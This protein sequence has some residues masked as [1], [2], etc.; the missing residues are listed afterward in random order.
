M[1]REIFTIANLLSLSR[2]ILI[3]P[4]VLVMLVPGAPARW[5]GVGILL[6]ATLTDKLDG[7]AARA[8]HQE[9]ELGR[10]LDPLADKLGVAA[11]AIVFLYLQWLPL[12]FVALLL[13]RDVLILTGGLIVRRK[14]G[15]VLPSNVAGKWSIGVFAA[16]L[17]FVLVDAPPWLLSIGIWTSVT[18]VLVS[19]IGYVRRFAEVMRGHTV[20]S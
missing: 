15:E 1:K 16:T 18:M 19:T 7:M 13:V 12:W 4:F 2:V 14:T 5:W 9:S 17:L 6:L 10:I 3:V 8:M 11:V 20:T